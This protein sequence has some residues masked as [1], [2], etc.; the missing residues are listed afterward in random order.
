MKHKQKQKS[1]IIIHGRKI[2]S[3]ANLTRVG[4]DKWYKLKYY[5][6]KTNSE[7][8]YRHGSAKKSTN[9]N[10]RN[11][12]LNSRICIQVVSH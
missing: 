11:D 8:K 3:L 6:Y 5:K 9:K 1:I 10:N 2:H 12:K 4:N 7:M